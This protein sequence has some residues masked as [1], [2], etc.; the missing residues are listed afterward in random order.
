[1]QAFGRFEIM[2]FGAFYLCVISL[3]HQ[4]SPNRILNYFTSNNFLKNMDQP[5]PLFVYF[6]I[7]LNTMTNIVHNLTIGVFGIRTSE[8]QD[9]RHRQIH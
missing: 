4:A 6:L 5:R 9:S 2:S 8:L 3:L 1:M 7:F